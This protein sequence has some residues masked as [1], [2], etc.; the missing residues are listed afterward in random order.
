MILKG[1]LTSNPT[2]TRRMQFTFTLIE[3]EQTKTII[4]KLIFID[5][6]KAFDTIDYAILIGMLEHYG[7]NNIELDGFKSYIYTRQQYVE[8]NNI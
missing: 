2:L 7:I 4:H 1:S 5:L 8:L 3:E 6:S